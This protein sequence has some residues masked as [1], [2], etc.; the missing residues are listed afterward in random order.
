MQS[1]TALLLSVPVGGSSSLNTPV[2]SLQTPSIT[3]LY[4]PLPDDYP[5]GSVEYLLPPSVDRLG[6]GWEFRAVKCPHSKID[7]SRHISFI[8]LSGAPHC[9]LRSL[10]PQHIFTIRISF[11]VLLRVFL[12]TK[13]KFWRWFMT[14]GPQCPHF[15]PFQRFEKNLK[16]QVFPDHNGKLKNFFWVYLNDLVTWMF[17]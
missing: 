4:G 16:K 7:N 8:P 15:F 9:A 14:A 13:N 11:F 10:R 17:H 12:D 3:G 1:I 5:A 6:K 2:V